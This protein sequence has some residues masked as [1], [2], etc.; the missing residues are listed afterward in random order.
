ME[1]YFGHYGPV[2]K[3]KWNPFS[4]SVFLSCSADWTIKLWD[5]E[6]VDTQNHGPIMS[7]ESVQVLLVLY[8]T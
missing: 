2:Y 7:F 3:V 4:P 8:I 1:T 6:L 5:E